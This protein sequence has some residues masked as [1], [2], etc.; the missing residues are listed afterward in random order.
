[1]G[2]EVPLP[3]PTTTLHTCEGVE[4]AGV[5]PGARGLTDP[6]NSNSEAKAASSSWQSLWQVA[7]AVEFRSETEGRLHNIPSTHT[8]TA[9]IGIHYQVTSEMDQGRNFKH[10]PRDRRF[11]AFTT[12]YFS[13]NRTF[14]SC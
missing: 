7:D 8:P 10:N 4:L 12:R 14:F 13:R 3:P 11:F 5:S 9:V 6:H 1:M 2:I